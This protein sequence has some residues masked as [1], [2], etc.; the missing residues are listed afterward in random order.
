[1]KFG[2]VLTKL[3]ST[4]VRV[5]RG[6][7]RAA[8]IPVPAGD[9]RMNTERLLKLADL[10]EADASNPDGIKFDLD[11]WAGYNGAEKFPSHAP[12]LDCRTQ[13]CAIGLA[14]LSGVFKKDG[15]KW[16]PAPNDNNIIPLFEHKKNFEAVELFFGITDAE[17]RHLFLRRSYWSAD[18]PT[19]GAKAERAVARRIRDLVAVA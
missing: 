5:G 19:R 11:T 15:L 1:M 16:Q 8:P 18:L 4:V 9:N 17:A 10:L 12:K 14:C 2:A 3:S 13:A 7:L 6:W